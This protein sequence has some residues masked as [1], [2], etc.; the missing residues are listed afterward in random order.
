MPRV[1]TP[2][3]TPNPNALRFALGE[4]AVGTASRSFPSAEAAAAVPWARRL[5]EI[6]G[7]VGLF[8]VND[9]VTVTKDSQAAWEAIV[10]HVVAALQDATFA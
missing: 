3:P 9:F 8:A 10:P 4:Q 6:P 5:F 2:E 7:V 1:V